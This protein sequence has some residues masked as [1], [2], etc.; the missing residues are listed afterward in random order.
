M[1]D[2]SERP[3]VTEMVASFLKRPRTKVLG[4]FCVQYGRGSGVAAH[5]FIRYSS[6]ASP[7]MD[8]PPQLWYS[9]SEHK[10]SEYKPRTMTE[11]E[12]RT[13]NYYMTENARAELE[14]RIA[15]LEALNA[16]AAVVDG[17]RRMLEAAVP[18]LVDEATNGHHF[19]DPAD[20]A[21]L[22]D[23]GCGM[24]LRIPEDARVPAEHLA[25]AV[26]FCPAVA[27]GMSFAMLECGDVFVLVDPAV[28]CP[29]DGAGVD[30]ARYMELVDQYLDTAPDDL[31]PAD[32]ALTTLADGAVVAQ[33]GPLCAL[34][35]AAPDEAALARCV[36]RM[37]NA[38]HFYCAELVALPL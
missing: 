33:C 35:P 28:A 16:P 15:R 13:M 29:E 32:L 9:N 21:R 22:L 20:P 24:V 11:S 8:E 12:E 1:N 26:A 30:L 5:F 27:P 38:L 25:A 18:V 34:L 36:D 17:E 23:G 37:V 3:F 7:R 19:P 10:N 2:C 6:V 31:T 4:L 14:S